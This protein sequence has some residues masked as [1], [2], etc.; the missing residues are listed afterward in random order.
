MDPDNVIQS[1]RNHLDDFGYKDIEMLVHMKYPSWEID[2]D[3]KMIKLLIETYKKLGKPSSFLPCSGTSLPLYVFDKL[4][5][6]PLLI[7]GLGRAA[8][9]YHANEFLPLQSIKDFQLSILLLL[10]KLSTL[11]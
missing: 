2:Y 8:K 7:A 10:S 1:L 6:K 9:A 4:L 11:I 5:N 3:N